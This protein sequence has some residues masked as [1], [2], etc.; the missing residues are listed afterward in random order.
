MQFPVKEFD[1]TEKYPG[2]MDLVTI[3]SKKSSLKQQMEIWKKS[4][5]EAHR[6]LDGDSGFVKWSREGENST[7]N[8]DELLELGDEKL[9]VFFIC[10]G[11]SYDAKN[12]ALAG[13]CNAYVNLFP[14]VDGAN[15]VA[16]F[17]VARRDIKTWAIKNHQ[18]DDVLRGHLIIKNS[19]ADIRAKG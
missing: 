6:S 14:D 16:T 11:S 1:E 2:E 4:Q 3:T 8:I 12:H 19:A 18:I 5:K 15:L 10:W 9:E 13:L 17:A 7:N